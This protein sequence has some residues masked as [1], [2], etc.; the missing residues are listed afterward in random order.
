MSS[1]YMTDSG[2]LQQQLQTAGGDYLLEGELPATS[3]ELK[4]C[5]PFD[6]REVVWNAQLVTVEEYSRKSPVADDPMQFID[7][8]K[9]GEAYRIIIALNIDTID[10]AAIERT[11]I[12]IRKYKRLRLGRHEYGAKSKTL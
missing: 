4:F 1:E 10:Q 11:I 7:I 12:M 2:Q 5:G 3:I 9:N 6:G 8:K